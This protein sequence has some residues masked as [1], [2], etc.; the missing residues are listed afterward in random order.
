MLVE[1]PLPLTP[2]QIMKQFVVC[3][4]VDWVLHSLERAKQYEANQTKQ[5]SISLSETDSF[6]GVRGALGE[7]FGVEGGDIV[8]YFL[9][10]F[11]QLGFP[12][13]NY[14]YADLIITITKDAF[15][16]SSS[17]SSKTLGQCNFK[18]NPCPKSTSVGHF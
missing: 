3:A 15:F 4:F 2:Q 1:V 11:P 9:M 12:N 14:R 18:I 17:R 16:P 5:G 7:F 10:S 6:S 8:S 13:R